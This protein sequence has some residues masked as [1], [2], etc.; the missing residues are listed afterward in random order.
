MTNT[1][2]KV[3]RYEGY[4]RTR[5]GWEDEQRQWYVPAADHDAAIAALTREVERLREVLQEA[6]RWVQTTV[7]DTCNESEEVE[8]EDF[9]ARIDAA[10]SGKAP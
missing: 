4:L 8:G 10:L 1:E 9:L 2:A 7:H 3:R 6:R 5:G